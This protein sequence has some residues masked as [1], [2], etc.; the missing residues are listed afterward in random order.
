M[1]AELSSHGSSQPKP[2]AGRRKRIADGP[3]GAASRGASKAKVDPPK[4]EALP[5]GFFVIC[6]FDALTLSFHKQSHHE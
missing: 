1:V 2:R 3:E 4:D 5:R 6:L